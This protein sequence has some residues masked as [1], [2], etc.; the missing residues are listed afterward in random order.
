MVNMA[1][2]FYKTEVIAMSFYLPFYQPQKANALLIKAGLIYLAFVSGQ[3]L[4][5]SL[6]LV[7]PP[8][9]WS[10]ITSQ[11]ILSLFLSAVAWR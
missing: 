11:F 3:T 2:P 4:A 10:A 5:K 8:S 6:D 7:G 1:D 9:S